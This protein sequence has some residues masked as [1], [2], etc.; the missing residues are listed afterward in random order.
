MTTHSRTSKTAVFIKR[1]SRGEQ[2]MAA[3]TD[4]AGNQIPFKKW[5]RKARREF[6]RIAA[7]AAGV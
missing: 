5:P 6:S 1:L 3:H 4:D 2:L 7:K